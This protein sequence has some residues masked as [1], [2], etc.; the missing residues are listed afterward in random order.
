MTNP[1]FLPGRTAASGLVDKVNTGKTASA[2]RTAGFA[3]D[4]LVLSAVARQSSLGDVTDRN[5]IDAIRQA[6]QNGQY[7]VDSRRIA[8][9]FL[10]LE[11][12]LPE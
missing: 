3:P 2:S 11:Q 8:E 4:E 10:A 6:I 1:I 5:R 9:V 7:P 12:S